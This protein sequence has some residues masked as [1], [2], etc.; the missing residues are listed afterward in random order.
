MR[1]SPHNNWHLAAGRSGRDRW[2]RRLRIPKHTLPGM[3]KAFQEGPFG[4]PVNVLV[5]V[6]TVE[7]WRGLSCETWFEVPPCLLPWNVR[8]KPRL[9]K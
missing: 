4:E 5:P 9:R 7:T 6:S 1:K 3:T 8:R 2:E